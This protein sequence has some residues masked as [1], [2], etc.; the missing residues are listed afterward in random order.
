[1]VLNPNLPNRTIIKRWCNIQRISIWIFS[2][3]YPS[4]QAKGNNAPLLR[5][6]VTYVTGGEWVLLI[7]RNT[8][9]DCLPLEG[10]LGD[11]H[12]LALQ[13]PLSPGPW[14]LA[15]DPSL[16]FPIFML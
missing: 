1:M 13:T 6:D 14:T 5:G 9:N 10:G 7:L 11:A 3:F 8:G 2:F 12:H 16:L 4:P 15:P